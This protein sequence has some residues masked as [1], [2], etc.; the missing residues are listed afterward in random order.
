MGLGQF[1]DDP[2]RLVSAARYL[3][4]HSLK[5]EERTVYDLGHGGRSQI[6]VRLRRHV[7]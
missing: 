7:A 5:P 6:E 1:R 2:S 4:W 3:R